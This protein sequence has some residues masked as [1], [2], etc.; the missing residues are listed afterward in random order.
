MHDNFGGINPFISH[1]VRPWFE[2]KA[3][4]GTRRQLVVVSDLRLSGRGRCCCSWDADVATHGYG[5]RRHIDTVRC[6]STRLIA[7]SHRQRRRRYRG[8]IV[9][10]CRRGIGVD[11]RRDTFGSSRRSLR[12]DAVT[13]EKR[14]HSEASLLLSTSVK[15]LEQLG[16]RL[17]PQGRAQISTP[18]LGFSWKSREI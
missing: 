6:R 7:D 12:R 14:K 8:R 3:V 1:S 17:R 9:R 18:P 2:P 11:G 15:Q 10:A 5:L 4:S 13:T 16:A